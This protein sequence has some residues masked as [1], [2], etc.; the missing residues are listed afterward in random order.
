MGRKGSGVEIRESSL[1]LRFTFE[2][3]RHIQTLML[4]GEAMPPTA[5]NIKY[6]HRLAV[7]I[8]GKIQHDT[9]R[10]CVKIT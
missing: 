10:R 1:R 2:G 6:A 7:E 3:K 5:A 8:K 4:N 9:F